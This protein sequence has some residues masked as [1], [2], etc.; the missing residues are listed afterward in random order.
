MCVSETLDNTYKFTSNKRLEI[1]CESWLLLS[2]F[3]LQMMVF[4]EALMKGDV[5]LSPAAFWGARL[6]LALLQYCFG[7]QLFIFPDVD[8]FSF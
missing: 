5:A 3:S 6:L 1:L 8:F 4:P 2:F 7:S